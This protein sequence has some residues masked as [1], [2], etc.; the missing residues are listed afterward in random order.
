MTILLKDYENQ[1]TL[2]NIDQL[3]SL[4]A[5]YE[6]DIH[7][8]EGVLND[9]HIIVNDPKIIRANN[10]KPR[11]YIIVYYTYASEMSNRLYMRHTDKLEVAL[12]YAERFGCDEFTEMFES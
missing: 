1:V 7:T 4:A 11:N 6:M 12:E 9:F 10:A 2:E 8:A 3:I 5:E